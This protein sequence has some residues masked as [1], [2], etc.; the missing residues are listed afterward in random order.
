MTDDLTPDTNSGAKPGAKSGV[1]WTRVL[2]FTSLAINLLVVGMVAGAFI[3][4]GGGPGRMVDEGSVLRDMG[5]G[6]YGQA[7]TPEE[8]RAMRRAV[9]RKAKDLATNREALRQ[10]MQTLLEALRKQPYDPAVVHAIVT[11]QQTRLKERWDIGRDLLLGH[12]DAMTDAERE[13]YAKRLARIVRR[14]ARAN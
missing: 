8:R 9:E 14:P 1:N 3:R 12:I 4:S 6:P 10:Q 5:Y 11:Q 13:Q 2:L 7:L